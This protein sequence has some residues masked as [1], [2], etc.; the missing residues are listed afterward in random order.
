MKAQPQ[1]N[2]AHGT[3]R[4]GLGRVPLVSPDRRWRLLV[5][6]WRRSWCA[7]G[8]DQRRDGGG[9]FAPTAETKWLFS[10]FISAICLFCFSCLWLF[11]G[12]SL[13]KLATLRIHSV[14]VV[15]KKKPAL[16]RESK[17]DAKEGNKDTQKPKEGKEGWA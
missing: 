6:C 10:H 5:A 13:A 1:V 11:F 16:G 15:T 7:A 4:G 3:H 9:A 8:A 17:R 2:T 12:G 14:S